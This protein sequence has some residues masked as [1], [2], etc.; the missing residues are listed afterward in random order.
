MS[1]FQEFLKDLK[2]NESSLTQVSTGPQFEGSLQQ[3]L[4]RSGFNQAMMKTDQVLGDYVRKIREEAHSK[5]ESVL[6]KNT[7]CS[8]DSDMYKDFYIIEPYGSQNFPDMMV[9]TQDKIVMLESKF[10]ISASGMPMW[11][12]NMPKK[13]AF[14]VFG[15]GKINSLTFFIGNSMLKE[16]TRNKLIELEEK[17]K[18]YTNELMDEFNDSDHENKYGFHVYPRLAFHQ[19]AEDK[20]NS[21]AF[22]EETSKRFIEEALSFAKTTNI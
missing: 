8:K 2:E 20:V 13:D 3:S 15:S 12:S 11:N 18:A 9:F 10:T 6:L 17:I 14:Y 19:V 5:T 22:E 16:Q 21:N 7:L 4:K 1:K